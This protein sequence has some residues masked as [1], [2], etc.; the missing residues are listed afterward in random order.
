[1]ATHFIS[2]PTPSTLSTDTIS[3]PLR[4]H[5]ICYLHIALLHLLFTYCVCINPFRPKGISH[6]NQLDQSISVLRDVGWYFS[7]FYNFNRTFC[8]QTVETLI[9]RRIL[10]RLIW[11]S[12]VCLC[13]TKRTLD[14]Y[15]LKTIRQFNEAYSS[16]A[17]D[18]L[19]FESFLTS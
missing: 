4:R 3:T 6:S 17:T 16:K 2:Q 18:L 13:P 12:T 10:W 9:R 7:L 19:F 11:I 15:V 5:T 14:L 8:Q 1:M